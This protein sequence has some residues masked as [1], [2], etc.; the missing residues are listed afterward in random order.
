MAVVAAGHAMDDL[1]IEIASGLVVGAGMGLVGAGGA[2]FTVPI[3]GIVLGHAPKAAFIEALAVTGGIALASGLIAARRGLV[4]WRCVLIF[5]S[6]GIVGTQLATPI[7]VRMNPT[8]QVLL[9]ALVAVV[10]AWRMWKSGRDGESPEDVGPANDSNAPVEPGVL[11]SGATD[12]LL[13]RESSHG[14]PVRS[15]AIGTGIGALTAILGVGGGFILI[16]A[17]VMVERMPM[18]IAVGTSL[19]VIVINATAGLLGQWWSGG[20][21]QV[22]V[23]VATV[24]I[25]IAGG[26]VGSMFGGALARRIPPSV[27]RSMFALLLVIAG[28]GLAAKH[29]LTAA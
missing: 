17:L 24:A 26:I 29:L 27:L 10:A 23:D 16:P 1:V 11:A 18:R 9:F 20:C 2:I 13:V 14:W 7:A 5:G 12:S 6:A 25:T 15:L 4:D 8:V 19:T 28:L 21:A 22:H 3:F